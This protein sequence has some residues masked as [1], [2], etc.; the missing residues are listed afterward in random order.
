MT[1]ILEVETISFTPDVSGWQPIET[2]PKDG[3]WLIMAGGEIRVGLSGSS[4]KSETASVT[5]WDGQGWK[6][7]RF[8][9]WGGDCFYRDPLYWLVIPPLPDGTMIDL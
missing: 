8:S 1:K 5:R 6:T 9:G 4:I 7:N 2:A 3:R